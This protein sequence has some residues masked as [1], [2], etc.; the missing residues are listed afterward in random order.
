MAGMGSV[1]LADRADG[2][3]EQ[4]VAIKFV[5]GGVLERR[6]LAAFR[7]RA[8]HSRGTR[9]PVISRDSSMAGRPLM[10]CRMS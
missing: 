2:E 1:Y 4:R 10:A 5:A 8:P 6:P 9:S 7:E 3:F